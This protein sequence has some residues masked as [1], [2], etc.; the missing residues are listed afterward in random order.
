M[1]KC[2]FP[3]IVL[4]I[5]SCLSCPV[6]AWEYPDGTH[7]AK[8]EKFGPRADSLLIKLYASEASEWENGLEAGEIDITD[9][10]LDPTH[11][12]KYTNAP[13]NSTLNVYGY[14]AEFG[15]RMFDL[16]NNN[17]TYLGN[18]PDPAYPNPRYPNPMGYTVS[19]SGVLHDGGYPLRHAIAHLVDRDAVVSYV[20]TEAAVAV[21]TPMVPSY[22][23]YL[24]PEI[25]PG[26]NRTDLTHPYDPAVATTILNDAAM[27]PIGTDGWRYWDRNRNGVYDGGTEYLELKLIARIDHAPRDYMGTL[28]GNELVAQHIHT[29]VQHITISAARTQWF[30]NKDA[31]IY[32]AGWSLGST[33]DFLILWH[34]RYY[35]HPGNSYNTGGCNKD[36]FNN[37][38]DGVQYANTQ[39]D[40]VY[41]ARIA[42]EVFTDAVLG[43]ALYSDSGYKAM[44][45]TYVGPEAMH[46]EEWYGAVSSPGYGIDNAF[47]FL[48]MHTTNHPTGGRINYGFNTV[49]LRQLNP[50]YSEWLWDN[51]VIDLIGYESLLK[52]N[53]YT[54]DLMPWVAANYKIETYSHPTLGTCT[55]AVFTLRSDVYFQD[56]IQLTMA[57]VAF[58]F[59]EVDSILAGRGLASPWWIS[60]VQNILSF[61]VLDPLNFEVLLNTTSIFAVGWFGGNRILPKHIW[62]PICE[63]AIAPK[64]GVAWDPTSFAPDPNLIGSGAWRL[65]EYVPVSHIL[66]QR[67]SVGSV[68]DTGITF[69]ENKNSAPVTSTK[70]YFRYLPVSVAVNTPSYRA[71]LNLP[72]ASGKWPTLNEMLTNFTVEISN[73]WLNQTSG[74]VFA[75]HGYVYVDG[76]L[77]PGY[78]V[79]IQVPT[80]LYTEW[81]NTTLSEG[82]HE[83]KVAVQIMGPANLT[84][85]GDN[86]VNPWKDKWVNVTSPVW[87]TIAEDIAGSYYIDPGLPAP[88]GV[89]DLKDYALACRAFG[90]LPGDSNW[91]RWGLMADVYSDYKIDLKDLFS[92]IRLFGWGAWP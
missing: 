21:Y 65:D 27:F 92:I 9:W 22:G 3:L 62:K 73:L 43:I 31:H 18:P 83:I 20:G 58:N 24:N 56:G 85:N 63:G 87:I 72:H 38:A 40:A 34:W 75:V 54:R 48:N 36:A 78:P 64:S 13:W 8:F 1:R 11:W 82:K 30:S 66:L 68:V 90:S 44:S 14:G 77:Q 39:D 70:G 4:I 35:W 50:I 17:N 16:N 12:V 29:N 32:T 19:E 7:D 69:D 15:I 57:D 79:E 10:P 49:E 67:N 37:A 2:L 59:I 26:G 74:G 55:K 81:L 53:P 47:T 86:I 84:E 89:A 61:K 42:Q 6:L 5:V 25:T 41:N 45:K 46:G 71:K 28:L 23:K 76:S 52:V 51:A 60:N 33:P 91:N 88:D 80:G